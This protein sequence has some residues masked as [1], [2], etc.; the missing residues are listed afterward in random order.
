MANPKT[1]YRRGNK[2]I[3]YLRVSTV[4]QVE[5][6]FGSEGLSLPA[7]RRKV[8]ERARETQRV[9]Y[10]SLVGE[11]RTVAVWA[12]L[13]IRFRAT[14]SGPNRSSSASCRADRLINPPSMSAPFLPGMPNGLVLKSM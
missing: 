2:G 5:T 12:R 10:H 14:G 6:E 1:T 13:E 3:A 7:Q 11:A 4:S 9:L 8:H